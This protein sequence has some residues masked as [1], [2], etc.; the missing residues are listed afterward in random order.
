MLG[1]DSAIMV[2]TTLLIKSD[3]SLYLVEMKLGNVAQLQP[4]LPPLTTRI[5]LLIDD[6]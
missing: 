1:V 6:I 2:I 5:S 4:L 3:Y